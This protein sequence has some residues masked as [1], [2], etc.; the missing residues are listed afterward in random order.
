MKTSSRAQTYSPLR[1]EKFENGEK[2]LEDP[3]VMD[4]YDLLLL[5]APLS[6][7]L[8]SE[9]PKPEFPLAVGLDHEVAACGSM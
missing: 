9:T 8:V 3:C 4:L 2:I 5:V 7:W 6:S 1:K